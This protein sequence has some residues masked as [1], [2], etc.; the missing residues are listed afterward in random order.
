SYR[1]APTGYDWPDGF[2]EVPL[3]Q[4]LDGR[5]AHFA[6]GTVED[7]DAVVMCTGYQHHFPFLP[8]ALRLRTTNRLYPHGM[9]KGVVSLADPGLLFLG[10]QDQYFTFNM[11]DAQAWF[12]REVMMGGVE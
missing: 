4:R 5:T 12:A 3:L 7:V 10:M 8:D 6:D 9:Y 11:F 2:D 1:S